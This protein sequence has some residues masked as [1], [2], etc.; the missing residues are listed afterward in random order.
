MKVELRVAKILE[1]EAVPK[2]KKL[3]KMKVNAGEAEPRTIVAGIAEAYQPEQLVGRTIVIVA[4]LKP[5]K[6]MGIESDGMVL[7][8]S[9]EGGLPTLIAVD[10]MCAGSACDRPTSAHARDVRATFAV[11]PA[12]V[13]RPVDRDVVGRVL[14]LRAEVFSILIGLQQHVA[15]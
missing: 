12:R 10:D 2:S 5:A 1:A 13:C 15:A 8:A 7:A 6:L 11:R 9:P 3:I 4:N 14:R